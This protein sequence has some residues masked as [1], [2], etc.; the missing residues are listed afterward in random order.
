[1]NTFVDHLKENQQ[2][3]TFMQLSEIKYKWK[4]RPNYIIKKQW[5]L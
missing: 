1:M 3:I 2:M 4:L 5:G